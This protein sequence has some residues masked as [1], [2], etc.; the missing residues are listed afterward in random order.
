MYL[1]QSITKNTKDLKKIKIKVGQ[2]DKSTTT[3]TIISFRSLVS[4]YKW[5]SG[6]SF[7]KLVYIRLLPLFLYVL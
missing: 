1:S 4:D 2:N 6:S 5:S 7:K 3:F